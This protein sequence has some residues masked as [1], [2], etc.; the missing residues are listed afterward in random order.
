MSNFFSIL[1]LILIVFS[2]SNCTE[3]REVTFI[4][5]H[6]FENEIWNSD[7]KISFKYN[8]DDS[9]SYFRKEIKIRHNSSYKFQNLLLFVK[10][11]NSENTI[12]SD[13]VNILLADKKSG[14]WLGEGVTDV[15]EFSYILDS[16]ELYQTGPQS[17]EFE[18]AM[19]YGGSPKLDGLLNVL[20]IGFS[21][22][23][24]DE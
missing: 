20:G 15:R 10:Q 8:I 5:Y 17:I 18:L 16:S 14:K 4:D 6:T 23:K 11:T 19:R 24:L 2:L 12:L 22:S 21:L 7:Q 1:F 3:K 9:V 13:T